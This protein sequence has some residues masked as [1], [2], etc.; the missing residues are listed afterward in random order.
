VFTLEHFLGE[1]DTGSGK[2]QAPLEKALTV[3]RP[4]L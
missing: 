2:E 1:M 4:G 3:S